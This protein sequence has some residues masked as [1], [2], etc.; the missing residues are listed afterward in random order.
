[1]KLNSKKI[2]IAIAGVALLWAGSF[3][4]GITQSYAP[5]AAPSTSV[6]PPAIA[7]ASSARTGRGS[8]APTVIEVQ[9]SS[10]GPTIIEMKP[11][12]LGPTI[13]EITPSQ[14]DVQ[15][16]AEP[17]RA[18]RRPRTERDAR[19]CLALDTYTAII[20]CAEKYL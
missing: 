15:V 13:I 5:P 17:P 19:H 3:T 2:G 9:P 14:G 4:S 11:S 8:S 18:P 6:K 12:S 10:L 7:P 16:A 1:M 20:K